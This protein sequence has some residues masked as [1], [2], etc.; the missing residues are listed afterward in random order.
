MN[1]KN[2]ILVVKMSIVLN[3]ITF[4]FLSP[5]SSHALL[6]PSATDIEFELCPELKTSNSLSFIL[7]NPE[8]PP[9]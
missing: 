8:I 9:R 2:K 3:A 6:I 7:G 5:E 4:V 1:L